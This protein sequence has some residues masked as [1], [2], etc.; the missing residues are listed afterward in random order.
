MMTDSQVLE[1][2]QH[3]SRSAPNPS[4]ATTKEFVAQ[5]DSQIDA[6]AEIPEEQRRTLVKSIVDKVAELR[7]AI[8]GV[9]DTGAL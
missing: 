4:D 6:S 5:W 3:L 7:G 1:F 2:A 9:R 8:E